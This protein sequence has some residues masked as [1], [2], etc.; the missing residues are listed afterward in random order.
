MT[1]FRIK[2]TIDGRADHS[3]TTGLVNSWTVHHGGQDLQ[4]TRQQQR[5]IRESSKI[6]NSGTSLV[7]S[8][9][10]HVELWLSNGT[11]EGQ[12]KQIALTSSS[13]S[14]MHRIL[15]HTYRGSCYLNNTTNLIFSQDA[16]DAIDG[17]DLA[18]FTTRQIDGKLRGS[19]VI[20]P[21][22][23]HADPFLEQLNEL[24]KKTKHM[25]AKRS[26]GQGSS[27]SVS[28]DGNVVACGGPNDDYWMGAIGA[29]WIYVRVP[30]ALNPTIVQMIKR[31]S[32][33]ATTAL[34]ARAFNRLYQS[35]QLVPSQ[36]D[37]DEAN[38]VVGASTL[39]ASE[40][41]TDRNLPLQG[42]QWLQ[43]AKLVGGGVIDYNSSQGFSCSLRGDGQGI[44]VGGPAQNR[45][46]GGVWWFQSNEQDGWSETG[47]WVNG[48]CTT[49]TT[50]TTETADPTVL[51]RADLEPP[52]STSVDMLG[53]SVSCQPH[54]PYSVAGGRG[55][56]C[57][58]EGTRLVVQLRLPEWAGMALA[59][60]TNNQHVFV[61]AADADKVWVF[62]WVDLL[63]WSLNSGATITPSPLQV[64]SCPPSDS[65]NNGFGSSLAST[66][67]PHRVVVGAHRW[68]YLAG[69]ALV[70]TWGKAEQRYVL[71][72]ILSD[73]DSPSG[74]IQGQ[75]SAVDIAGQNG[76]LI[77]VGHMLSSDQRGGCLQ[78]LWDDEVSKFLMIP[79]SLVPRQVGQ[80][81]LVGASVAC[82]ARGDTVVVG[83]AG[84][85]DY[86]SCAVFQ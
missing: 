4:R 40:T 83:N 50:T 62:D 32:A 75:G 47:R 46:A 35:M 57:A 16:W 6:P 8:T 68:S 22:E 72:Q 66:W 10:G 24:L 43:V 41:H 12:T 86:G 85:G 73:T 29:V 33:P 3:A 65:T 5:V 9:R 14:S 37:I 18:W 30:Q 25:P 17:T 31:G 42:A 81:A 74:S 59:V 23:K 60:D 13:R 61:G 51:S 45:G 82:S 55:L 11:M 27:V 58:F 26:I 20:S 36:E 49:T 48:D 19:G 63:A 79:H 71:S 15:L 2:S 84:D 56:V 54:G 39:R 76:L 70:Y 34:E 78:Y 69:A 7:D 53:C 28:G 38:Q 64:L 67:M 77:I 44:I 21:Y 52:T 80:G 1:S